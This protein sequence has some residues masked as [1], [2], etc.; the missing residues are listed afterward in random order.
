MRSLFPLLIGA[1]LWVGIPAI[2]G[3]EGPSA[4]T[5][6]AEA[7]SA[8]EPSAQESTAEAPIVGELKGA[9]ASAEPSMA[10]P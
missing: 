3:A 8:G 6:N 7:R 1:T 5:P 4:D 2:S 9:E 10:E